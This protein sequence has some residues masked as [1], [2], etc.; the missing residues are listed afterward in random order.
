MHRLVYV[1]THICNGS[2]LKT[3]Q[4]SIRK[5]INKQIVLQPSNGLKRLRNKGLKIKNIVTILTVAMAF[6]A[7]HMSKCIHWLLYQCVICQMSVTLQI[8]QDNTQSS[9]HAN[10]QD[11]NEGVVSNK[12]V[13]RVHGKLALMY[14][15]CIGL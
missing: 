2:R 3:V 5:S 1:C 10:H 15:L 4:I 11:A 7:H 6:W 9:H 8:S 13:G 12:K 14:T